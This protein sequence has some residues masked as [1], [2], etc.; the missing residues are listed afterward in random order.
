M[1]AVEV[2]SL[3]ADL[4]GYG[5]AGLMYFFWKEERRERVRYRDLHEETLKELPN[6]TNAL[7]ELTDEVSKRD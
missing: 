5:V 3:L 1:T 7:K 4:G 6:L 2:S